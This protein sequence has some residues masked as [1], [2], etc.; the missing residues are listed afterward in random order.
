M[1]INISQD[2]KKVIINEMQETIY[3]IAEL[4]RQLDELSRSITDYEAA[5]ERKRNE[6]NTLL[7]LVEKMEAIGARRPTGENSNII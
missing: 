5:A 4:Y 7:I 1:S 3:D 6:Y 2:N